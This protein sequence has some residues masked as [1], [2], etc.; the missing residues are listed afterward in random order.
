M[1][2]LTQTPQQNTDI[3]TIKQSENGLE[4]PQRYLKIQQIPRNAFTSNPAQQQR[5]KLRQRPQG[6]ES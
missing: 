4:T 1:Q 6:V 2:K 3:E 5:L